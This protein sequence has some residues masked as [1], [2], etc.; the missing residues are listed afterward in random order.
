MPCWEK[1]H[2]TGCADMGFPIGLTMG[3]GMAFG[4]WFYQG[5]SRPD[6]GIEELY[7]KKAIFA[8]K[9]GAGLTLGSAEVFSLKYQGRC[10]IIPW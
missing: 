4:L 3:Q 7:R 1:N 8:T 6:T 2:G 9:G 10:A 5:T